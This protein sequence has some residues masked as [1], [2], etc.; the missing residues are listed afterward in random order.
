MLHERAG[1]QGQTCA[2]VAHE[3]LERD[4][5]DHPTRSASR[6]SQAPC[7][8]LAVA[9]A[10]CD[11]G[12]SCWVTTVT[13]IVCSAHRALRGV[14]R[15]KRGRDRRRILRAF[16]NNDVLPAFTHPPSTAE[17]CALSGLHGEHL[18]IGRRRTDRRP[19]RA[20]HRAECSCPGRSS[21]PR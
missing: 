12:P 10:L 2:G 4:A 7:T 18:Q 1:T 3:D 6:A 15:I 21:S 5:H 16:Y 11:A 9:R 13:V 19:A 20:G 8:A 17:P 14:T